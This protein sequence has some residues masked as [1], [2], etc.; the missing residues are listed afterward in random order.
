MCF[1]REQPKVP[2]LQVLDQ[3]ATE[4]KPN[5]LSC[6][7]SSYH[8]IVLNMAPST[9]I[10]MHKVMVHWSFEQHKTALCAFFSCSEQTVR[11]CNL[12]RLSTS[13]LWLSQSFCLYQGLPSHSRQWQYI[14]T[15]NPALYLDELQEQLFAA[16]DKD[17]SLGYNDMKL[18]LFFPKPACGSFS[19]QL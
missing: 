17:V 2:S 3:F 18:R 11:F 16:Q 19:R 9:S 5:N 1:S 8:C 4:H 6:S 13:G 15:S 7:I 10:E 12:H 14:C